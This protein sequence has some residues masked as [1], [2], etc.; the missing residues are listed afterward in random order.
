MTGVTRTDAPSHADDEKS[1]VTVTSTAS[2]HLNYVPPCES[3]TRSSD[4]QP[5]SL[6][7]PRHHTYSIIIH[8][9]HHLLVSSADCLMTDAT[10]QHKHCVSTYL[11]TV[12]YLCVSAYLSL[13]MAP[14]GLSPT[15]GSFCFLLGS[16][17][18]MTKVAS[19]QDVWPQIMSRVFFTR[20]C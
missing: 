2:H 14:S 6:Q 16:P 17:L 7:K 15:T 9:V 8:T 12:Q 11:Y 5:V 10:P 20:S 3:L 4:E 1:H 19:C 18:K 13:E